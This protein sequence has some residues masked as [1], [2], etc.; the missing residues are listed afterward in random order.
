MYSREIDDLI[1]I[2]KY[3]LESKEYDMI[4]HTSPQINHIK[5]E[6][7]PSGYNYNIYTNDGYK[8]KVK[9]YCRRKNENK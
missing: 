9:V 6:E 4:C 2:K 8:W 1:K 5:Y 7:E 3:I